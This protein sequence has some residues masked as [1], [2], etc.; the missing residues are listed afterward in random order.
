[1]DERDWND[2]PLNHGESIYLQD[3]KLTRRSMGHVLLISGEFSAGLAAF[4]PTANVAGLGEDIGSGDY[5]I[6][7]GRDS[8]LLN[9]TNATRVIAGWHEGGYAVSHATG[10]YALIEISGQGSEMLLAQGASIRFKSPSPSAA[11]QFAGQNCLLVRDS[12][13]WLLFVERPMLTFICGFLAS[14]NSTI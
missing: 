4:A 8:I 7:I 5:A 9:T 13:N 11:I 14:S 2:K 10:K 12:E 6:R 3:V 1:M